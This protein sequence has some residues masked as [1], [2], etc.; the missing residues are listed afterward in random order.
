MGS[1]RDTVLAVDLQDCLC[2][3]GIVMLCGIEVKEGKRTPNPQEGGGPAQ[4]QTPHVPG[5]PQRGF[6]FVAVPAHAGFATGREPPFLGVRG[7]FP[8]MNLRPVPSMVG[9]GTSAAELSACMLQQD[10]YHPHKEH[11]TTKSRRA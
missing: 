8:L 5:P 9:R 11:G 2:L 7:P 1:L 3:E 6:P 4:S 10:L